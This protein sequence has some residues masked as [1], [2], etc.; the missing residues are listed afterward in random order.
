MFDCALDCNLEIVH[1]SK[2][3]IDVKPLLFISQKVCHFD[4]IKFEKSTHSLRDNEYDNVVIKL[5]VPV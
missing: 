4:S 2:I 5:C 1:F 3:T